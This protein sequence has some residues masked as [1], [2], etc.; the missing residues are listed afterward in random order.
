ME[1]GAFAAI[2]D[3]MPKTCVYVIR[4]SDH[5]ILYA[6]KRAYEILPNVVLNQTCPGREAGL[7]SVCMLPAVNGKDTFRAVGYNARCDDLADVTSARILWEDGTPAY[8]ITVDPY[9]DQPGYSYRKVIHADLETDY[10]RILRSEPDQWTLEGPA[11][12]LAFERFARSGAVHPEDIERLIAFTRAEHLRDASLARKDAPTLVYRR[13]INGSYRWNLMEVLPSQDGGKTTVI[14]V[15]DVHNVLRESLEREEMAVRSQ[16]LIRSLGEQNFSIYTVN[17][18]TGTANPIRVNNKMCES[19]DALPWSE[20]VQPQIQ[21]RLHVMYQD[22]FEK[23][24]SLEGLRQIR[25]DGQ[26][27]FELLCRWRSGEDYRYISVTAH[28]NDQPEASSYTVVALQDVDERMRRELAHTKRDR[29]M[30]AILKS[31]YRMMNTVN[32]ETGMCERVNLAQ[33]AA[34]ENTLVGDYEA[35]IQK[36]LE[37]FVH[38]DDKEIFRNALSLEH[39][40]RKAE[41]VEDYSDEICQYRL[42]GPEERW[43]ELHVLYSRQKGNVV[44]NILGQDVTR[45]KREEEARAHT[46]EDR[47][48]MITSLSSLYFSTYYIDLERDTFRAVTQQHRVS[49]V[50]GNEMNFTTALQLYSSQFIHPDDRESYLQ[51]MN[52]Q[53]FRQSLRWWQPYVSVEYRKLPDFPETSD[54]PYQWVR[55]TAMLARVGADDLPKTAVYVAKN[56]TEDE[57]E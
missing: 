54:E 19:L 49:D 28:F 48:Y 7:C 34:S 53:N 41:S 29:Q 2:L 5:A 16:E 15:K 30:A 25:K 44:V 4:E 8:V 12:S 32:L 13:L 21:E 52:V 18:K 43:I 37:S 56:I 14:C 17:L 6:N 3:A 31:R 45:E 51:V 1:N 47:A 57:R 40:R 46:L 22:E 38:P 55:A 11:L 27:K 24:F 50:L 10:Y 33:A 36:A 42:R 23:Y 39:L 35:Y 20:A 26:Q 9:S